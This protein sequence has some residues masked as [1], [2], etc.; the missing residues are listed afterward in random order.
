MGKDSIEK[1]KTVERLFH[2]K[3]RFFKANEKDQLKERMIA[4]HQNVAGRVT[5]RSLNDRVE[6]LME[7][8]LH[9]VRPYA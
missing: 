8:F 4:L 7:F 9:E 2:N 3:Y 1:G 6:N 5:T